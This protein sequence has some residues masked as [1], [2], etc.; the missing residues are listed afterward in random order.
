MYK[1]IYHESANLNS[2]IGIRNP[3][4]EDWVNVLRKNKHHSIVLRNA[5]QN[6]SG[7]IFVT[8]N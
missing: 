2:L 4:W 3:S 8:A 5:E 1:P 7:V 6:A